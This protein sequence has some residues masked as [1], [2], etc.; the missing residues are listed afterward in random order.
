M[1]GY[2]CIVDIW[3]ALQVMLVAL[4]TPLQ[5][6]DLQRLARHAA[7]F[8]D[9]ILQ[10]LTSLQ[11]RRPAAA[12]APLLHAAA[13]SSYQAALVAASL[14]AE[15]LHSPTASGIED[16]TQR[17]HNM[18][19]TAQS[20]ASQAHA[21]VSDEDALC[22]MVA[23]ACTAL[24]CL[25]S[26]VARESVFRRLGSQLPGIVQAASLLFQHAETPQ[27][28]QQGQQQRQQ[29][30]VLGSEAL[31][32]QL[33]QSRKLPGNLLGV[34]QGAGLFVGCCRLL[35]AALRHRQ[36]SMGSCMPLLLSSFRLL[37]RTLVHWCRD[38]VAA[39][40]SVRCA[41]DVSAADV[42]D[43]VDVGLDV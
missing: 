25:E 20:V 10:W 30:T 15:S 39:Q 4:E 24:R 16:S 2:I 37:L 31:L 13:N 23:A 34:A 29:C 17:Q 36:G 27:H 21:Q 35:S 33:H 19:G 5:P 6:K 12:T 3:T 7:S 41:A 11:Q 9:A 43:S 8:I 38:L 40:L 22:Y 18:P 28:D 42:S 14:Q 1:P 32:G 26:I